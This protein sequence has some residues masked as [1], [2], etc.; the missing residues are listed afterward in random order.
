[1][2]AILLI[3][4]PL[5]ALVSMLRKGAP[6]SD[7]TLWLLLVVLVN[8]LGPILYFAIGSGKLDEKAA[9]IACERGRAYLGYPRGVA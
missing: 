5:A 3:A 8:M 1:M 7:K 9:K 6:S 2:T 4:V